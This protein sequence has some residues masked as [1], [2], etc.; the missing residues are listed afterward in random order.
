VK[1]AIERIEY[2]LPEK[3]ESSNDLSRDNPDWDVTKIAEKTGISH[4]YISSPTE[5][6]TMMGFE[7][8]TKLFDG[9]VSRESI[10]F[11]ILV[12]QTPDYSIPTSACILQNTLQLNHSV[13]AFDINLGCSGFIYA[14][15]IS[16]SL[17][18][19]KQAKRGIVICSEKY[20]QHIDLQDRTCRPLFS[21]GAAA[22]VVGLSNKNA[23]NSFNLG[24]DGSGYSNLII[25]KESDKIKNSIPGSLFMNGSAVFMF[26]MNMVP[27][28]I[29]A[30]LENANLQINDIDAFIFHQ[31]GKVVIDE[32]KKKLKLPSEKVFTNYEK[33]GNTVS[34]SIPIALK[35]A[36]EEKFLKAGDRCM[37]VGFGVGYSWGGCIIEWD[38]LL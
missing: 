24:S 6:V 13:L 14:L 11:L 27:K 30:V 2:Y 15:N 4:R 16:C 32:I 26:T 28:C 19:S 1:V 38:G 17:I 20:T 18:E 35:D 33:V 37:L 22:V 12:T 34:A 31:A 23:I 36:E 3:Q 8:A 9:G 29:N 25:P 7:A 10:D 5:T 21:D